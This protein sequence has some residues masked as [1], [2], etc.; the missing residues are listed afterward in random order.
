MAAK[1]KSADHGKSRPVRLKH[2]AAIS[3]DE[4]RLTQRQ[5]PALL[6]DLIG[7]TIKL[8]RNGERVRIRGFGL[9]Q[10]RKRAAPMCRGL[11]TGKVTIKAS[12]KTAFRSPKE[13]K[14]T[15]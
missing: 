14:L 7:L 5:N 13:L 1:A 6:K 15:I 4:H 3:A 12:E 10:L 11:A 9:P 8:L 2:L